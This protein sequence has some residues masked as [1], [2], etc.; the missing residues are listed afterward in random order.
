VREFPQPAYTIRQTPPVEPGSAQGQV[1]PIGRVVQAGGRTYVEFAT[2]SGL[3]Y[4]V[5]YRDSATAPWQTSAVAVTGTGTTIQWLDDG[6]PKTV[7]APTAARTYQLLVAPAPSASLR[8]ITQPQSQ[9]VARN[10]TATLSVV[11]EVSSR[12][13][14]YQWFKDGRALAGSTAAQLAIPAFGPAGIGAYYVEVSDGSVLLRSSI[15]TLSL[16]NAAVGRIVNLSVLASVEPDNVL[17]A[18]FAVSGTS[19]LRLLNRAVGPTLAQFG[20]EQPVADSNLLLYN[21]SLLATN[22]DWEQDVAG[23]LVANAAQAVGAFALPAGSKDAA[24][25]RTLL[26]GTFSA[27]SRNRG[28]VPATVLTEIYDAGTDGDARLTNISSRNVVGRGGATLTAGFVVTGDQ[29]V[30]LLIRGVGPSL[31]AFGVGDVLAD[32]LLTLRRSDGSVVD[33]N[34]DWSVVEA[35][36]VAER[37]FSRAGAFD[38]TRGSRDAVLDVRLPA[39][40]YTATVSAKAGAIGQALVE[41]YVIE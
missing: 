37:L 17:I 11:A 9:Q 16:A 34:D 12:G 30:R 25:L 26:P 31:A 5:Q 6:W 28:A 27:H 21:G 29:P 38:L 39:G 10:A 8:I 2:T 36:I 32:P 3:L 24:L 18:G 15:A 20:V 41:V 1:Q 40:A 35:G 4:W 7:S 22:E 14:A 19:S 13:L 33:L 23:P